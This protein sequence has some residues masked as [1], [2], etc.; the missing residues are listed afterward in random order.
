MKPITVK[1][2]RSKF[3]R[4]NRIRKA[5]FKGYFKIYHRLSV[6]GLQNIP[7]GPAILA[8]NHSGGFDLDSLAISTS[9]HRERDVMILFWD[10]YHFLNN[11]WGRYVI[12]DSIP[13]WLTGGIRYEYI[14]PFLKPSGESYPGLVC[15]FPEGRSLLFSERKELCT[16]YPGVIRLALHYKVP[17][18]PTAMI[19][20]HYACPVLFSKRH[21]NKPD[22]PIV[23]LPFTIP[24]KLRIEYG[25]PIYLEEYY[26]RKLTKEEEFDL[27]NNIVKK[28]IGLLLKK[29]I[30]SFII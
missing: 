30:P 8:A 28:K 17:I 25:K 19:G 18:V 3:R 5:F 7:E 22:D 14:D 6:D 4:Y 15:M 10:K 20:F 1:E 23:Y 27:A 9:G 29:H 16:F 11:L 2:Y 26:D 21:P 24:W 13:L 12:G